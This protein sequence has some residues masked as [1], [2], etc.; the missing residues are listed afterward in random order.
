M[1]T[2]QHAQD[3]W[4]DSLEVT[5]A[6]ESLDQAVE[7]P[8]VPLD[9]T[10]P[11]SPQ[12]P[13]TQ[14][15]YVPPVDTM[16]AAEPREQTVLRRKRP[17]RRTDVDDGRTLRRDPRTRRKTVNAVPSPQY[18]PEAM[19]APAATGR[20]DRVVPRRRALIGFLLVILL[21]RLV[22]IGLCGLVVVMAVPSLVGR[23]SLLRIAEVISTFMPSQ[24]AGIL[25]IPTPFDGAFRGDIAVAA[26]ALFFFEYLLT[27]LRARM[28]YAG[29][30]A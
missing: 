30:R 10:D 28:K 12:V 15:A 23:L 26:F 9:A 4:D 19:P 8:T 25:V 11:F 17:V 29:V 16:R 1:T 24:L 5:R 22:A 2:P 14:P 13:A 21:I 6:L 18:A 20:M 7:V 3:N 27:R